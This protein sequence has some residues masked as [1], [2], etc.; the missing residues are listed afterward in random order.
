MADADGVLELF[1]AELRG[2]HNK[3]TLVKNIVQ[4]GQ[5]QS[6]GLPGQAMSGGEAVDF[7]LD[8]FDVKLTV[9]CK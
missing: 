8:P 5:I 3:G 9:Q 1:T 2:Q 6:V 4:V 7:A